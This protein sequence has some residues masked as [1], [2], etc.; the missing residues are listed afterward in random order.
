[1]WG[2]DNYIKNESCAGARARRIIEKLKEAGYQ[3]VKKEEG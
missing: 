2:K 1:L 3:I